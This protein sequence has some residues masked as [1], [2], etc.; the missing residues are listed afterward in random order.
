MASTRH[1]QLS[2]RA[3]VVAY[4]LIVMGMLASGVTVVA[5]REAI[6]WYRHRRRYLPM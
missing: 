2:V 4:P 3:T 6:F 1:D 5:F